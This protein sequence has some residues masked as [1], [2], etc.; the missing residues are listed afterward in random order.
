MPRKKIP[1]SKREHGLTGTYQAGCR[2]DDCKAARARYAKQRY[3]ARKAGDV[4]KPGKPKHGSRGKYAKGCRCDDCKAAETAYR[5]DYDKRRKEG[6]AGPAQHAD[7]AQV[8]REIRMPVSCP[9][10]GGDVVQQT[11]SAVTGSG[12]RVTVMLRCS[13]NGCNRQWQF[14]GVLMSLN[15]AEYM[16]AA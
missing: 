6:H 14:V 5:R 11:P 16:G 13:K 3:E 9:N 15:G 2:C 7:G 8:L 10:C 4:R 1:L 12:M